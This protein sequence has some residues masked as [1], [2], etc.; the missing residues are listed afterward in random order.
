V[1][2]TILGSGAMARA[3]GT[4]ALVGGHSVQVLSRD[5][6][7]YQALAE[8]LRSLAISSE[9]VAVGPLDE[10]LVGDLVVLAVPYPAAFTLVRRYSEELNGKV[11]IDITNPFNESFDGL[12]TPP[13]TSAAEEIA[14]KLPSGAGIVKAFNTIFASTLADGQ[15]AGQPLDVFIAGDDPGAKQTVGDFAQTGGLRAFD[16]GPLSRARALEQ[17][18]LV[19]MTLQQQ[20]DTRFRSAIKIIS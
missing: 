19:H 10:P 7:H 12:V 20:L 16:A 17:F 9:T 11:V 14:N 6:E 8:E 1:N 5:A 18:E 2:L 15:V 13:D 4:R 3:I